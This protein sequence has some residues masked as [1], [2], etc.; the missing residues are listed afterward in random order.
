MTSHVAML[1]FCVVA[2]GAH[3]AMASP[4]ATLAYYESNS[5][6]ALQTERSRLTEVA[7]DLY[8]IDAKG[9]ISG[10]LPRRL[11]AVARAAH[12]KLF[13]TVSNFGPH[14]FSET[15]GHAVL[16]DGDVQT[17][18]L[19]GL[20]ALAANPAFAGVN[21][22]ALSGDPKNSW[23]GAFD[24]AAIGG[25]CDV[26]QL[27]TYDENGPWGAPG[28]V[29][30]FDWVSASLAYTR[31]VVAPAKISLG[32]PAYGYDWDI[33]HKTGRQIAEAAMPALIA[34]TGATPHWNATAQSPWL[35]YRE[36]NGANH[37]VWYENARSAR[38]KA[39]LVPAHGLAGVSVYALGFDDPTYWRA[40]EQGFAEQSNI[41]TR[42]VSA[43]IKLLV[44]TES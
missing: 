32:M 38:I 40:I 37:V 12:L 42:R 31:T 29:A 44:K 15:I 2:L 27:M 36:A 9:K 17:R 33:T 28:P 26:F 8:A 21:I 6:L 18:A 35:I 3:A 23:T 22:A 10:A 16:T 19:T 13:A 7:A 20:G 43:P 39:A 30:G 41:G 25:V 34:K 24:Y 1:S 4:A 5:Q 11:D 14:G